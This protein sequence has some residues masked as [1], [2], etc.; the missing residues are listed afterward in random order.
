MKISY[1]ILTHNEGDYIENLL[2]FL[3][4]NIR[5]EDEIVVVDDYSTDIKTKDT[6]ERF[7]DHIILNYRKFDG[8]ATQK[9]FLNSHC[10]GDYILQLDADELMSKSILS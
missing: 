2:S 6:L 8:D 9:N 5:V 10:T 4:K 3:V 1:A 7:K